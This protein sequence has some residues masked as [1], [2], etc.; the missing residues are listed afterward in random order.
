MSG[1]DVSAAGFAAKFVRYPCLSG[2]DVSADG[3]DTTF[4]R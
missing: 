2:S 1:G 3:S 4:V